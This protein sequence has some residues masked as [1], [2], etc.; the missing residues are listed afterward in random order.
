MLTGEITRCRFACD[1][2]YYIPLLF[3][4]LYPQRARARARAWNKYFYVRCAGRQRQFS[5]FARVLGHDEIIVA[6][7]RNNI[8]EILEIRTNKLSLVMEWCQFV[9]ANLSRASTR[10]HR[11]DRCHSGCAIST[12]LS[13]AQCITRY[14]FVN[15][16][17]VTWE[18]RFFIAMTARVCVCVI[19]ESIWKQ[20]SCLFQ[21]AI[22]TTERIGYHRAICSISKKGE[23]YTRAHRTASIV[24]YWNG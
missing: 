16:G 10:W 20:C 7:R 9:K 6:S 5:P 13:T 8:V 18:I 19:P 2:I 4:P 21:V 3:S 12:G 1:N 24:K 14:L 22:G 11:A 23:I 17:S 15:D